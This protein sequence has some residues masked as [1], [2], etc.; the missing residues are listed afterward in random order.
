[1]KYIS[2]MMPTIFLCLLIISVSCIP[3]FSGQFILD[4]IAFVK[5]NPY[6]KEFHTLT[7]YLFQ[8]DGIFND[9]MGEYYSGYYRPLINFTYTLDYKIWGM[10]S[11][12]GGKNCA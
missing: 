9:G 10:I 5:E 8:E 4:D 3:T 1:M 6:I 2:K 12:K 11:F 7:S